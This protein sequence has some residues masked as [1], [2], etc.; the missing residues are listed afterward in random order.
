M[1]LSFGLVKLFVQKNVGFGLP[2]SLKE[3]LGR[4]PFLENDGAIE[5]LLTFR[6]KKHKTFFLFLNYSP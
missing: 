4:D 2:S 5:V 6:L 1:L 3:T